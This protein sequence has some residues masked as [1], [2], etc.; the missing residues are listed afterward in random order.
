MRIG[1][2]SDTHIPEAGPGLP[3]AVYSVFR[4][5]DIIMHAGDLHVIDVLDWLEQRIGAPVYGAR[6]NGD[7][8]YNGRPR[9][10][11]DPRLKEAHVLT[12][13]GLRIGLAH[14]VPLPDECPWIPVEQ[15]MQRMFGGPVDVIVNGDTHVEQ[16]LKHKGVLFVNPGSPTFPHNL[17]GVPGHVALLEVRD[18]VAHAE[19]VKLG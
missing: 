9:V 13:E 12:L 7:T 4:G 15:T 3:D 6:G 14:A 1:L 5:V 17:V 11:D 8:G 16:I 18:G 2:I 19:I 10:R